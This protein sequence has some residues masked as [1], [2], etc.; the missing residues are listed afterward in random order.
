[1]V[2]LALFVS[3]DSRPTKRFREVLVCSPDARWHSRFSGTLLTSKGYVWT[4]NRSLVFNCWLTNENCIL[5]YYQNKPA[6]I[7]FKKKP[8]QGNYHLRVL[9]FKMGFLVTTVVPIEWQVFLKDL[10]KNFSRQTGNLT[11]RSHFMA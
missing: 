7:F 9:D 10:A 3:R 4:W 8:K 2:Y 6:T 5:L 11:A 1:M